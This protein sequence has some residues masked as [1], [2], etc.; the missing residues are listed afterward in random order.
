[1]DGLQLKKVLSSIPDAPL[2]VESLM[3]DVDVSSSMTRDTFNQLAQPVLDRVRA[4]LLQVRC[5]TGLRSHKNVKGMLLFVLDL[6]RCW[7]CVRPNTLAGVGWSWLILLK[8]YKLRF[9][10]CVIG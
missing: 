6:S 8:L 2:N 3:D 5:L 4:P 1:M 7:R 9:R 10:R